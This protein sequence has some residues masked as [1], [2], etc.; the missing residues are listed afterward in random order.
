L[1][2]IIKRHVIRL[3]GIAVILIAAVLS[4]QGWI[5]DADKDLVI[6]LVLGALGGAAAIRR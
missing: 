3:C 4:A 5:L 6:G 2:E 1:I